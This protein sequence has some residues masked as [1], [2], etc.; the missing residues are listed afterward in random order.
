M[1][2]LM[3]VV[4]IAPTACVQPFATWFELLPVSSA[5]G[6]LNI[7]TELDRPF[8]TE[9]NQVLH[10]DVFRPEGLDQPT[11]A[12]VLVHGGFWVFGDRWYVHDWAADL[13]QHGYV[14]VSIDYRLLPDGGRYPAPVT[15]VLAAVSH[16]RDHA[17]ELS[18]DPDRIALFGVSAGAHLVL[19]AG[20]ADDV[21]LFDPNQPAGESARIRAIV[22]IYGPTDFT[23]SPTNASPWQDDLVSDFLGGRQDEVPERWREASPVSY[24]RADGPPV[25]VLHGTIDDIVPVTQAHLLRDALEAAGQVHEYFEVPDVGHWWGS[26]WDSP[27]AQA[28]RAGILRFLEYNLGAGGLD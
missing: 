10:M 18:V 22:E 17:A 28:H 5:I 3:A 27:P 25:F 13:A 24:A 4:A 1:L 11:P 9:R 8:V 19:L 12:V 20:M 6:D 15:D 14:A 7:Q 23:L 16:L 2:L 21:S 26:D